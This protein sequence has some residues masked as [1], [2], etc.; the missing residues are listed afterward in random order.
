M[1]PASEFSQCPQTSRWVSRLEA[2]IR[3][4]QNPAWS[5]TQKCYGVNFYVSP[6]ERRIQDCFSSTNTLPLNPSKETLAT[7][8][9]RCEQQGGAKETAGEKGTSRKCWHLIIESFSSSSSSSSPSSSSFSFFF[10]FFAQEIYFGGECTSTCRFR[11]DDGWR[12][13]LL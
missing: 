10:F 13:L 6:C 12:A 8:R 1:F 3:R 11:C 9:G 4:T 5:C 2:L 7:G